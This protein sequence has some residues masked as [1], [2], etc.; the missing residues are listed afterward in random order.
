MPRPE[1]QKNEKKKELTEQEKR[2]LSMLQTRAKYSVLTAGLKKALSEAEVKQL[3][4]DPEFLR[5]RELAGKYEKTLAN[6]RV[7]GRAHMKGMPT[8]NVNRFVDYYMQEEDTPEKAEL[9][10]D[11]S[12]M[13]FCKEGIQELADKGIKACLS[14]DY[15]MFY[16]DNEQEAMDQMLKHPLAAEQ[17]MIVSKLLDGDRKYDIDPLVEEV[18]TWNN[19][20]LEIGGNTENYMNY[21]ASDACLF[22]KNELDMDGFVSFKK[23][24]DAFMAQS[25]DENAAKV[26]SDFA[27]GLLTFHVNRSLEYPKKE[28]WDRSI[29]DLKKEGVIG[30]ESMFY[31][32][33]ADKEHTQ[34]L[35]FD[36]AVMRKARGEEIH[37]VKMDAK[38]QDKLREAMKNPTHLSKK[39]EIGPLY[40]KEFVEECAKLYKMIDKADS[41]FVNSSD[42]FRDMKDALKEMARGEVIPSEDEAKKFLTTVV[43]LTTKYEQ[44]KLEKV[45]KK[46]TEIEEKNAHRP[47]NKQLPVPKKLSEK[48]EKRRA[49]VKE[50]FNKLAPKLGMLSLKSYRDK[51]RDRS[52]Y[53]KIQSENTKFY[54]ERKAAEER[55]K[56]AEEEA[57]KAAEARAKEAE[58][59]AREARRFVSYTEI[60]VPGLGEKSPFG[61]LAEQA[62]RGTA[63]IHNAMRP[64][65]YWKGDK[66][67]T[68]GRYL[69]MV[70]AY[71]LVKSERDQAGPAAKEPG[72]LETILNTVGSSKAFYKAV[73]ET[74]EIQRII[75]GKLTPDAI[76]SFQQDGRSLELMRKLSKPEKL[77]EISEKATAYKKAH[78]P[79]K[80]EP[81]IQKDARS[82][83]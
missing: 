73:Q 48:E 15:S 56:A 70:V 8:T 2:E 74:E 17:C 1:E 35:K 47:K 75:N 34:R 65:A 44:K 76:R 69:S 39:E 77:K 7:A 53:E 14:V 80:A 60:K 38:E 79:Q 41:M 55:A 54:D 81:K 68:D 83:A 27:F 23:Y 6:M 62:A 63:G 26:I 45:E 12:H 36:D 72:P 59:K 10:A 71:G 29:T 30:P 25:K 49:A 31:R 21:Y 67:F 51:T 19:T 4:N 20:A 50:V 58:R 64:D 40:G 28:D 57:R 33:Y 61:K 5:K 11:I 78:A 52:F 16:P 22:M 82:M 37:F 18:L 42:E 13:I 66:D 24:K 3:A 46:K 32:A 43:E 9:N